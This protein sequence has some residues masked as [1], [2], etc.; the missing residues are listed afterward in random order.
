MLLLLAAAGD[1]LTLPALLPSYAMQHAAIL[2]D[3]YPHLLPRAAFT[4]VG[5][6]V[7]WLLS[8]ADVARNE[9]QGGLSYHNAGLVIEAEEGQEGVV[10][11]D[12]G[13]GS[14]DTPGHIRE[15]LQELVT[16]VKRAA[17]GGTG[18]VSRCGETRHATDGGGTAGTTAATRRWQLAQCERMAAALG[19]LGGGVRGA[20]VLWGMRA[21]AAA[22]VAQVQ[23]QRLGG[24]GS[25]GKRKRWEADASVEGDATPM[26]MVRSRAGG[27]PTSGVNIDCGNPVFRFRATKTTHTY[28]SS[29]VRTLRPTLRLT[30]STCVHRRRWVSWRTNSWG[31]RRRNSGR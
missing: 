25:D 21:R 12:G 27:C 10:S 14:A 7:E 5:R 18:A 11:A 31:C 1:S 20:A 29:R 15:S 6:A 8:P 30:T 22:L 19:K 28:N 13:R 23:A 26:L 4:T 2:R 3:Q 9:H 16:A 24:G 17:G